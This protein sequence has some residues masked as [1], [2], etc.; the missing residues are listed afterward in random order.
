MRRPS[1]GRRQ[2]LVHQPIVDGLRARGICVELMPEPGDVL[3]YG[4]HA[5]LKFEVFIPMEF[6]SDA[7][8]RGGS[9]AKLTKTQAKRVMPIPVV[10]DLPE[11]LALF[12]LFS[13]D[14]G[15]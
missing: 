8:S 15:S 3:C 6:K 10:H 4:W 13:I 14:K 5:R 2:D 9:K 1:A 12:G 11:A 7:K